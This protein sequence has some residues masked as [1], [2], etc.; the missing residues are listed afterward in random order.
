MKRR[1]LGKPR[2]Q[3]RKNAAAQ[4]AEQTGSLH[5]WPPCPGHLRLLMVCL[6][7]SGNGSLF[8]FCPV[9]IKEQR[10]THAPRKKGKLLKGSLYIPQQNLKLENYQ[11]KMA[12]AISYFLF[13]MH[14]RV[15]RDPASLRIQAPPLSL[16]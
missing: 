5:C 3:P 8:P 11:D 9:S 16:S 4:S 6:W 2:R 14:H 10:S 15:R 13:S 7:S 12:Q 1:D